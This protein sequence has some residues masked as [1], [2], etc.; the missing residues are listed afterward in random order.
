MNKN[1]LVKYRYGNIHSHTDYSNLRFLDAVIT[2]PQAFKKASEFNYKLIGFTDHG[3]IS[4][5]IKASR[6]YKSHKSELGDLKPVY[7]TELYLV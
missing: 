7:G 1:D 3:A 2:V 6:Y 4:S 5:H